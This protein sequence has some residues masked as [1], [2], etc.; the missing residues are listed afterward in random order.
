GKEFWNGSKR[1]IVVEDP[2]HKK[3]ALYLGRRAHPTAPNGPPS[4]GSPGLELRRGS[5]WHMVKMLVRL[6]GASGLIDAL[7]LFHLMRQPLP[8]LG[9]GDELISELS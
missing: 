3:P 4:A 6:Y 1:A 7:H 9:D 5:S 2:F 8:I